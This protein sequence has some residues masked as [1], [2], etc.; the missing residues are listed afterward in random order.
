MR[1]TWSALR[2]VQVVVCLVVNVILAD[3]H[4][5]HPPPPSRIARPQ[6]TILLELLQEKF[7]VAGRGAGDAV[8]SRMEI[9]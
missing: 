7:L 8:F 4:P 1:R 2:S 6:S 5:R 3:V 9:T